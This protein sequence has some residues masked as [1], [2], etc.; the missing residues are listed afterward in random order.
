MLGA[1][2]GVASLA[3]G[4]LGACFVDI[5]GRRKWFAFAFATGSV[6]L[7]AIWA[8]GAPSAWV[9]FYLS[10][11]SYV[12]IG[13]MSTGTQLYT[14]ELYPTRMRALATSFASI[15]A[16]LASSIGPIL[17][18]FML[19]DFA[20]AAVFLMLGCFA[21]AG[22]LIMSIFGIETKDRVLEDISH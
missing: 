22:A 1:A 16:R 13:T 10:A 15:W 18:G 8:V 5:V 21:V 17:V 3:A 12:F 9:V 2:N 20:L 11:A 4:L 6:P 19:R 14:P 7:F